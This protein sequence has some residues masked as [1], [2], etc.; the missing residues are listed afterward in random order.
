MWKICIY[1]ILYFI[2]TVKLRM[3][4]V[5]SSGF[6]FLSLWSIFYFPLL[7]F[8]TCICREL[9]KV[10]CQ[11]ATMFSSAKLPKLFWWK[12]RRTPVY[13]IVIS[14]SSFEIGHFLWFG[15]WSR[16]EVSHFYKFL[17]ARLLCLKQ[18]QSLMPRPS[19]AYPCDMGMMN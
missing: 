6:C 9:K 17:V 14:C 10:S 5:T 1:Q 19:H 3:R 11:Y 7:C 16:K 8:G 4:V 13:L 18:R 12:A 15:L 2:G